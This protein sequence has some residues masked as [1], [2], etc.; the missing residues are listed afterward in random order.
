VRDLSLRSPNFPCFIKNDIN[1]HRRSENSTNNSNT[2]L[3]DPRKH[4]KA[5]STRNLVLTR[6]KY[7]EQSGPVGIVAIDHQ[8]GESVE[9]GDLVEADSDEH[10]NPRGIVVC[11]EGIDDQA[12]ERRYCFCEKKKQEVGFPLVQKNLRLGYNRPC[13]LIFPF[14]HRFYIQRITTW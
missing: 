5:Y 2:V 6:D 13:K 1:K 14:P 3:F 8:D 11:R 4:L 7:S 10:S 9:M 12:A